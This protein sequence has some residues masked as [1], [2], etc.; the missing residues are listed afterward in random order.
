MDYTV[1]DI[2]PIVLLPFFAFVLNSFIVKPFTK[3]AVAISVLAIFGSFIYS[4]RIFSD[5]I[6]NVHSADYHVHK[7][8]NWFDLSYA[9]LVFKVDLGVYLDNMTAVMLLMVSG[10]A[11]LIHVFSTFYMKE[12]AR[13]GRFFVYLSLFS[14]AML[15]L[16]LADNLLLFFC[17]WEIMGFCSYSLIGFYY[18]KE[19]AG[20]ASLKAFMTTRVGDVFFL[21]GILGIWSVVGSVNLVDIYAG[22]DAGVF[23]GVTALTIPLATLTAGA[24]FMGTI[25]KSAQF[26]LQVWL[27][28]AM[29]GPTPCS[30]LIHAATMV[31][32]GV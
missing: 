19:E 25:G 16:V 18:E 26:P 24:I 21:F 2:A 10:V 7:Y 12:D 29:M 5:F 9:D 23:D 6:F 28:D 30:A 15:G 31:A 1:G 22:I 17:F 8:F 4:L 14:A 20:D 11:T 3:S 13:F 32:A 27:P